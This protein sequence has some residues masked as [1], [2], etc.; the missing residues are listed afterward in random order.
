MYK[1][2]PVIF[3]SVIAP[4]LQVLTGLLSLSP[5]DCVAAPD[6]R[7][8]GMR[9]AIVVAQGYPMILARPAAVFVAG[10]CGKEAAKD[11]MLRMEDRQML[12]GDHFELTVP[13]CTP[14]IR[15]L[16][17]I[18][19]MRR[20]EPLKAKIKEGPCGQHVGRIQTEI[21]DACHRRLGGCLQ[22]QSQTG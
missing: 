8:D 10:A 18:E 21:A 7:H 20:R 13:D 16:G 4:C 17:C 3:D 11:A 19:V 5:K 12:I 22:R 9:T 14:E 1:L 15:D 6:V 2:Q